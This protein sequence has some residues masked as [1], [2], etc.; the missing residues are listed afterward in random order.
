MPRFVSGVNFG[1]DF[2]GNEEHQFDKEREKDIAFALSSDVP[3]ENV[4]QKFRAKDIFK[5]D[6]G[7]DG[8]GS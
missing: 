6:S 2:T 4:I 8:N 7:H 5:Q 3:L 1:P